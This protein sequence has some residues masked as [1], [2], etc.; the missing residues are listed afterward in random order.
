M[1]RIACGVPLLMVA[2][3]VAAACS[4]TPGL[5]VGDS[6]TIPGS[7]GSVPSQGDGAIGGAVCPDDVGDRVACD[8]AVLA[9]CA[10]KCVAGL[11]Y[12]FTCNPAGWIADNCPVPCGGDDAGPPDGSAINNGDTIPGTVACNDGTGNTDCCPDGVTELS[13]CSGY[14]THCWTRCTAGT[15]TQIACTQGAWLSGKGLFCCY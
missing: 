10:T 7:D 9:S 11:S 4:R 13:S 1:I 15:Q 6:G 14:P 3:T 2:L 12:H 5:A 8:P